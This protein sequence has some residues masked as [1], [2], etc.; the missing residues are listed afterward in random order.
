[1]VDDWPEPSFLRKQESSG[2]CSGRN[3]IGEEALDSCFRRN[4]GRLTRKGYL[5]LECDRLQGPSS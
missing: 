5:R 3:S 1:M 4:G 2:F